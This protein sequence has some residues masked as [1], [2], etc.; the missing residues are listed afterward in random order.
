VEHRDKFINNATHPK[1]GISMSLSEDGS[2][3]V[4][5]NLTGSAVLT[6]L[7]SQFKSLEEILRFDV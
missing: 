7:L 2:Y 5:G 4:W 1:Y 3:F 6:P